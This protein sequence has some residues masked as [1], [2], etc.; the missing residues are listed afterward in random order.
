ML[1]LSL[2]L[3]AFEESYPE[4]A[5]L[6]AMSLKR[7]VVNSRMQQNRFNKKQEQELKKFIESSVNPEEISS[8]YLFLRNT[9]GKNFEKSCR[10]KYNTY[11]EQPGF[12]FT[13][14]IDYRI[15]CLH[16]LGVK[17]SF[18]AKTIGCKISKKVQNRI[19]FLKRNRRNYQS[20]T[21]NYPAMYIQPQQMSTP[22]VITQVVP[23]K[24]QDVLIETQDNV[25]SEQ[26][27][28]VIFENEP[29][30]NFDVSQDTEF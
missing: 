22:Q 27:N 12:V 20:Y 7:S 8:K 25:F 26:Y 19:S 6:G 16:C 5:A 1:D 17:N 30:F 4:L 29:V 21:S 3:Q 15:M 24:I 10:D 13:Q 28:E 23:F 14:E 9:Y 2:S 18:I 11:I